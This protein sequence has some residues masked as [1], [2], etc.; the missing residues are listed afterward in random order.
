MV[1]DFC[2]S[3]K[4]LVWTDCIDYPPSLVSLSWRGYKALQGDT[5]HL[6]VNTTITSSPYTIIDYLS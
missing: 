2:C 4:C 1:Y 6:A 3:L 5:R